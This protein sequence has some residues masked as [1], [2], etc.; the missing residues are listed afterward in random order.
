MTVIRRKGSPVSDDLLSIGAFA[1]RSRL[2]PKALRLYER[3]ALLVPASVDESNGYRRYRESQLR[4]ARMV[5]MLRRLD[6]PIAT[7]RTMVAIPREERTAFLEQYWAEVEARHENQRLIVEHFRM[8]LS[9]G[10]DSYP[11]F[12]V[13]TRDIPELLV[14]TEQT[15]IT[16][17]RLPEW[18]G[19]AFDR[20]QKAGAANGAPMV[21]YHGEVNEDS[22]GP[23]ESAYPVT[24]E[25]A[26]ASDLPTRT[27]PAHREAYVTI[28]KSLVRYPDILSAFDA[29]EAWINENGE[30]FNGSPR[31]VYFADF[32]AAG[33]DDLV[34]DI[35]FPIA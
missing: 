23:V 7:I 6:M 28:P 4:D 14:F 18:I 3:E 17:E 21:I 11:M 30:H 26:A 24:A 31:E 9:G 12:D 2:S 13:K 25:Q 8:T 29:V 16:A 5:R 22:D 20:A 27:E 34:C 32:M 19:A 1:R 33:D 10:K 35:A 15:H